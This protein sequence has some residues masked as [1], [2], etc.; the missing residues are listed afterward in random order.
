MLKFYFGFRFLGLRHHRHVILHLPTKFRS[1]RKIRGVMT[2]YPFSR[3]RKGHR[4]S[5]FGF[6]FRD[7]AHPGRSKYTCIP[8]FGEISQ[9][10]TEIYFWFL[11]PNVRHA[12]I[13]LPVSIFTF[14][15]ISACRSA[16][17]YQISSKSD[18]P[19]QSYEVIF[20]F[21]DGGRQPY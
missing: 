12:G 10:S 6:V 9:F 1:N 20:I 14:A 13:L 21:K 3:W 19:R 11:K 2:S 4:N 16:S 8:N 18:H 5:T 17:V 7:F 15:S